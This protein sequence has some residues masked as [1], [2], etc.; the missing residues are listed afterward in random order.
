MFHFTFKS[1]NCIIQHLTITGNIISFYLNKT[2]ASDSPEFNYIKTKL[3]L[4]TVLADSLEHQFLHKPNSKFAESFE[5]DN[6]H[7]HFSFEGNPREI[8]PKIIDHIIFFQDN[9]VLRGLEF[10]GFYAELETIRLKN[11]AKIHPEFII[12]MIEGYDRTRDF[13][14]A[15]EIS[16]LT[17]SFIDYSHPQNPMSKLMRIDGYLFDFINI[18][19]RFLGQSK[20]K[21]GS[22]F[23][24]YFNNLQLARNAFLVYNNCS[25]NRVELVKANELFNTIE[26]SAP[27][28]AIISKLTSYIERIESQRSEGGIDFTYGF[29]FFSDSRAINREANYCLAKTLRDKLC[30]G[31]S[32]ESVFSDADKTRALI[33][34]RNFSKNPNYTDRGLNSSELNSIISEV[35]ASFPQ[36]DT[37]SSCFSFCF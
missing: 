25:N 37:P 33:V 30:D 6:A 29:W 21:V 22:F 2:D 10:E 26:T 3:S 8:V 1:T 5:D 16:N 7:V 12:S 27:I 35:K 11:K 15:V 19:E 20:T 14:P 24:D 28:V 17:N 4:T 13:I 34:N 36:K 32:L 31:K 23:N 18:N 9:T